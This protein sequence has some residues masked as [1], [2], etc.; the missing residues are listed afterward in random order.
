MA[1]HAQCL[2]RVAGDQN[3][4]ALGEQMADK[5]A[6]GVS[7]SRARRALHQNPSMFLEL[8]GN[9]DLLG[10]G[11]VSQQHLALPFYGTSRGWSPIS[12]LR[13]PRI[14][15]QHYSDRTRNSL[16]RAE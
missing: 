15:F 14:I 8:L 2:C 7:F 3:A 9:S 12:L 6:D 4:L 10:I 13:K 11:G 1:H 5:I 16:A